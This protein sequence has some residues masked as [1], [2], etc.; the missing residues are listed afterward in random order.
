MHT[1]VFGLLAGRENGCI[2]IAQL[3]VLLH[4]LDEL[5]QAFLVQ[6]AVLEVVLG[7]KHFLGWK[8]EAYIV[9]FLVNGESAM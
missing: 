2:L 5:N 8:M 1:L 7:S 3:G 6:L 4:V 9:A